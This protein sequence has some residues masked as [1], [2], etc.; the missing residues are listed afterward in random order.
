[1][2]AGPSLGWV[3]VIGA[4]LI[5]YLGMLTMLGRGGRPDVPADLPSPP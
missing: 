3:I 2:R 1:L 4:V 5:A